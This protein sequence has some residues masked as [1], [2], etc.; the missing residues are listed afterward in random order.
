MG[1]NS[2]PIPCD[3]MSFSSRRKKRKITLKIPFKTLE[4][5]N[6]KEARNVEFKVDK[7]SLILKI[8]SRN[9]IS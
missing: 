9:S 8:P 5:V 6:V 4:I 7:L 3:H 1:I 2:V